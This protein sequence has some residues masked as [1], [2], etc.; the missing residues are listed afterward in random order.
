VLIGLLNYREGNGGA[1]ATYWYGVVFMG[2][3]G[4]TWCMRLSGRPR[5]KWDDHIKLHIEEI[6]WWVDID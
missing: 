4:D 5:H 1:F 3:G 2:F 6:G